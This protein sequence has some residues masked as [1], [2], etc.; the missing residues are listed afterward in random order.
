ME[1]TDFL[2][3]QKDE[4]TGM[5][6]YRKL[7]KS[8]K[9]HREV[10]EKIALDEEKHYTLLKKLT[11]KDV[12]PSR[13]KVFVYLLLA[14]ILGLTFAL[15]LMEKSEEMA[16]A[17]YSINSKALQEL[18]KD[19]EEHERVLIAL[20]DEERLYY[21]GSMVLGLND[22]IVELTGTLAGLTFAIQKT[23]IVA[24]SG[25]ITGIAAAFSMAASNYLAEKA[26][27]K[28]KKPL[29]SAAY[30]GIAY[31]VTVFLL[32]FPFLIN[33]NPFIALIFSVINAVLI[34]AIFNFFIYIVKEESFKKNF[35]EMLGISFGVVILSFLVGF[36]A[37]KFLGIEI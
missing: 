29:K 12:G 31:L 25:I 20:I 35:L 34:I 16:Q 28:G 36:I 11:G 30:T 21:I 23:S 3:L 32:T 18:L 5:V 7:A 4:A 27:E 37:R 26:D 8:S 14:K 22:A 9:A 17:N 1:N 33:S 13:F 2:K 15:K 24:L 10:L 6:I 19:E